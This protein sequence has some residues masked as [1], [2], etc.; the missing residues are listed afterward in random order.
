MTMVQISM[1]RCGQSPREYR[2]SSH[3]ECPRQ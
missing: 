1:T 2:E 3:R